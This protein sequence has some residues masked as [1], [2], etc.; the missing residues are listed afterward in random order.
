MEEK[1]TILKDIKKAY[2]ETTWYFV[3]F[4]R[5]FCMQFVAKT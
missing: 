5:N 2:F 4:M 3:T 1:G